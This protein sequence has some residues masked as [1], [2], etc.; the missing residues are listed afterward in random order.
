MMR[1]CIY[2]NFLFK[3]LLRNRFSY[4]PAAM[5]VAYVATAANA[6]LVKKLGGTQMN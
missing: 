1:V 6:A 4:H 3:A 2:L 5:L